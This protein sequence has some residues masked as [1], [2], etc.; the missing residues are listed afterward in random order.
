MVVRIADGQGRLK[1]DFVIGEAEP[2]LECELLL[3]LERGLAVG[4]ARH[5]SRPRVGGNALGVL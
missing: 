4:V 2:G 5:G 3:G 1:D